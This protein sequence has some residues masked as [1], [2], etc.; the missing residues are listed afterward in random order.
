M[1]EQQLLLA[2]QPVQQTALGLERDGQETTVQH[3][4]LLLAQGVDLPVHEPRMA[5]PARRGT[6]LDVVHAAL[7]ADDAQEYALVLPFGPDVKDSELPALVDEALQH[8]VQGRKQPCALALLKRLAQRGA[9][10]GHVR[11]RIQQ[12]LDREAGCESVVVALLECR[13]ERVSQGLQGSTLR[14]GPLRSRDLGRRGGRRRRR[15]LC[16]DERER[17]REQGRVHGGS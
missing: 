15:I 1:L 14:L 3:L 13:R 2:E 8:V 4:R 10:V 16:K 11:C 12:R 7:L 5:P 9:D 17:K 6:E